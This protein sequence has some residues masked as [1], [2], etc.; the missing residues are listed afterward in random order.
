MRTK[1][2][3][4]SAAICAGG[5]ATSMAQVFSEN[6]VGYYTLQLPQG[7][8][9]IANQFN[10]GD[11]NLNTI[12]PFD[13]S[14]IG[15]E[16]IKW[17]VAGQT[18]MA[19]DSFFGSAFQGWVDVNYVPTATTLVPGEGAFI[20]MPSAADV[21]MVGEVPQGQ[22][23]VVIPPLFSIISQPTPQA[24][25]FNADPQPVPASIG[26]QILFWDNTPGAQGYE[27]S[28]DYFGP[29]FGG[30]VDYLYV[31]V[32]PTP[33]IGESVFYNSA[34]ATDVPWTRDFDV[35]QP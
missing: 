29:D 11:N 15:A 1:A 19:A 2:L 23:T 6:A 7:F 31:P 8:T 24:L 18:F 14:L 12:L 17:D 34:A 33:E 28:L 10:N 22:L 21:T 35:N 9:M 20:N 3:V 32:D 25:A 16:L 27:R 30:W 13:D 4:L 26:D 5:I